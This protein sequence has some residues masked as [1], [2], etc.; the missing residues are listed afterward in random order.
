MFIKLLKK[1]FASQN[2]VT[3]ANDR[4]YDNIDS[5][6]AFANLLKKMIDKKGVTVKEVCE[7]TGISRYKIDKFLSSPGL[8]SK[9]D[10][11]TLE[12]YLNVSFKYL[13]YCYNDIL[14]IYEHKK[15]V[16]KKSFIYPEKV[17]FDES[18][19]FVFFDSD[20]ENKRCTYCY[21]DLQGNTLLESEV[22]ASYLI[23]NYIMSNGS[24]SC[25][26]VGNKPIL[27]LFDLKKKLDVCCVEIPIHVL[28][29]ASIDDIKKNIQLCIKLTKGTTIIDVDFSGNILLDNDNLNNNLLNLSSDDLYYI[30]KLLIQ[31]YANNATEELNDKIISA[32]S[33]LEKRSSF[34]TRKKA[35]LYKHLG[36]ANLSL[37]KNT[38]A[39]KAFKKAFSL[40]S[41]IGVKKHIATLEK[42]N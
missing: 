7:S 4:C 31:E 33:R 19:N 8:P 17:R 40:D 25:C 18:G 32:L 38:L 11:H 3:S 35:M 14:Y 27:Y 26:I 23:D 37:S 29:V 20:Y 6:Y 21:M 15:L 34:S 10:L 13:P 12:N 9:E 41:N 24:Y 2:T 36:E 22:K 39:L 5:S 28:Y 1:L 42:A 30:I 16:F